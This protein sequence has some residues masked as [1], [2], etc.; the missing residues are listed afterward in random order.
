[1]QVIKN[2]MQTEQK[3][4]NP[5]ICKNINCVNAKNVKGWK[6]K[7]YAPFAWNVLFQKDLSPVLN[8]E[9]KKSKKRKEKGNLIEKHLAYVPIVMNRQFP[10]SVAARSTMQ[11]ALLASQNVGS[12]RAFGCHKSNRKNA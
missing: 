5:I 10:A 1:M 4:K 8:A 2:M 11:A 9:Q 6:N 3:S 12:Q 7:G